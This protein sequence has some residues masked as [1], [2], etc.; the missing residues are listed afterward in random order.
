MPAGA[1]IILPRKQ[2]EMDIEPICHIYLI[3]IG[4]IW[5]PFKDIQQSENFISV[6]VSTAGDEK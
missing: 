6:R 1:F 3:Q 5:L 4:S 2:H